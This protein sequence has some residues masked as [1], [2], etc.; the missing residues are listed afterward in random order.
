MMR[1]VPQVSDTRFPVSARAVADATRCVMRQKVFLS[2]TVSINSYVIAGLDYRIRSRNL[3]LREACMK[4]GHP[5]DPKKS[6]FISVDELY[7]GAVGFLVHQ[8]V[9]RAAHSIIS[10]LPVIMLA[11]HGDRA[12]DWF[13]DDVE[14]LMDGYYWDEQSCTV[15]NKYEELNDDDE[16]YGDFEDDISLHE[17]YT[18]SQAL[19]GNFSVH[20]LG[21]PPTQQYHDEGRTVATF[22][23]ACGDIVVTNMDDNTTSNEPDQNTA[24]RT[25]H[26]DSAFT[27]SYSKDTPTRHNDSSITTPPL[28]QI[29]EVENKNPIST[30]TNTSSAALQR[31]LEDNPTTFQQMLLDQLV[32]NPTFLQTLQQHLS[33]QDKGMEKGEHE[34]NRPPREPPDGSQKPEFQ[35]ISIDSHSSATASSTI[36]STVTPS[37]TKNGRTAKEGGQRT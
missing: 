12:V 33:L 24:A 23:S 27:G 15:K 8:D 10:T 4:I 2:K 34:A 31:F 26:S 11:W 22:A 30:I 32:D 16:F 7:P 21:Q 17:E 13:R 18:G 37:T 1:F 35:A 14:Q 3:T 6:L 36:P 29:T 20:M 5:T 28:T 19:V 25:H 9:E